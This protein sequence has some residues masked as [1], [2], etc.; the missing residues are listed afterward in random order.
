MIMKGKFYKLK[1]KEMV[2]ETYKIRRIQKKDLG[3]KEIFSVNN[4]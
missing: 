3:K 1:N 2:K 4:I